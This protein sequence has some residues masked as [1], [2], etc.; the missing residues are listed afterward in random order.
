[1]ETYNNFPSIFDEYD[2]S[3][4]ED[5][6]QQEAFV[7]LETNQQHHKRNQPVY[8]NDEEDSWTDDEE[9]KEGLLEQLISPSCLP[10]VEQQT[11]EPQYD[12]LELEKEKTSNGEKKQFHFDLQEE[13]WDDCKNFIS[14]P[15]Y[16]PVAVYMESKWGI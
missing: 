15:F 2:E 7:Q 1:M 5:N 13:V 8:D 3:V 9:D 10:T 4:P 14:F 16:D 11:S 12:I 6:E